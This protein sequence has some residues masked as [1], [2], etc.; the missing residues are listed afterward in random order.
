MVNKADQS[1][2]QI[3]PSR[4]IQ[5][6][7]PQP[8]T[9]Q[10]SFATIRETG[11]ANT[12]TIMTSCL[13]LK[14]NAPE[15]PWWSSESTCQHRWD[16]FDPWSRKIP[17]AVRQLSPCRL[18][19]EVSVIIPRGLL[20]APWTSSVLSVALLHPSAWPTQ[21]E[22]P[23]FHLPPPLSGKASS[24]F[25]THSLPWHAMAGSVSVSGS[26]QNQASSQQV[27]GAITSCSHGITVLGLWRTCP[28][29][30]LGGV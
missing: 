13:A 4:H 21:E 6:S 14:N 19:T 12:L 8:H 26:H 29:I 2:R 28:G 20:P 15:L 11:P 18:R 27:P 23:S 24:P 3:T 1:V 16:K 25:K 9:D 17:H 5:H 30:G 10:T 22:P 7:L